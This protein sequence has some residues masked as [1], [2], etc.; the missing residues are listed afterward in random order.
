MKLSTK[1]QNLDILQKLR[2]QKSVIPKFFKYSVEEWILDKDRIIKVLLEK[3]NKKI[4]IRSSYI[5]E[6]SEKNSM[7]CEFEGFSNVKNTKKNIFES[8]TNL[9]KQYKKKSK[10]KLHYLKSEIIFQNMIL[11]TKLSG[12]LTNFCI[13]DGS[14]YYVINYDDVSGSTDSVTSG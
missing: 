8:V 2:L 11:N 10:K 13:K 3:L 7:A 5:L 9:I 12:V 6:D 14:F 4:I 1:A